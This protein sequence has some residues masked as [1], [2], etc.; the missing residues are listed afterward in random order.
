V[1]APLEF[2]CAIG[3]APVKALRLQDW[4][5]TVAIPPQFLEP[6]HPDHI[7]QAP[8]ETLKWGDKTLQRKPSSFYRV[9]LRRLINYLSHYQRLFTLR[10][11]PAYDKPSEVRYL[12]HELD[13]EEFELSV[14]QATKEFQPLSGPAPFWLRPSG[15]YE[16]DSQLIT[17]ELRI[18]TLSEAA[19]S[20]AEEELP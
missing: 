12:A 9:N 17:V 15:L 19:L 4:V 6:P 8:D 2:A 18:P 20:M 1:S 14:I 5:P 10:I 7:S 16:A 11:N 13:G 3:V